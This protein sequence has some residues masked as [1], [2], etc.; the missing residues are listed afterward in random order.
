MRIDFAIISL[1]ILIFA[2]LIPLGMLA[3][4]A[5]FL[6]LRVVPKG[7]ARHIY[8]AVPLLTPAEQSFF[9][10]LQQATGPGYKIFAK[11]RLADVVH[12]VR[13]ASRSGWQSAFNR[14]TGKHVDFVLCHAQTLCVLAAIELDDRTHQRFE[15][16]IRDSLVDA[17]LADAS[18]PVLRVQAAHAYSLA[19][20]RQQIESLIRPPA[21][22]R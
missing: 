1:L 8:E 2:S 21:Q 19:Q 10:V 14:I 6:R 13:N 15:R 16:G 5:P 7:V 4:V 3:M 22:T 9:G 17:A 11:V 18:I 12:P 20:I